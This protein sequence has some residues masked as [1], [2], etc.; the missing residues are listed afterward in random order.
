VVRDHNV[1]VIVK[2]NTVHR[3][4]N[5]C[6]QFVSAV[7]V[8]RA[9]AHSPLNSAEQPRSTRHFTRSREV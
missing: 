7:S 1:V 4:N 9:R 2:L 8:R 6:L 3:F 5:Y